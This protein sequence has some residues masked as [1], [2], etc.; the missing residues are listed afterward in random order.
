MT[1]EIIVRYLHFLGIGVWV[2]FL[3]GELVLLQAE[4]TRREINRLARL[5]MWYGLSAIVVVS[6]GLIMWMGIGKPTEFYTNNPLF[7]LKVSLAGLVGLLSIIPT[8]F[9][10]R[11]RK[12]PSEEK[13]PLPHHILW[14]VRVELIL[15]VFI[16][17]LAI[18]AARGIGVS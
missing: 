11:Q 10:A 13:I 14:L 4:M 7:I 16:P 1:T 15:M 3:A 18:L 12:G 17:L 2:A 5:D 6:M 9:F 8:V